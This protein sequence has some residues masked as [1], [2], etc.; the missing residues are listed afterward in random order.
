MSLQTLGKKLYYTTRDTISSRETI[1][2]GDISVTFPSYFVENFSWTI[3]TERPV[4][5]DLLTSV[6][7]GDSFYDIGA[8]AGLYSITV[9]RAIRG[10][11]TAFE[12]YPPNVDRLSRY[13]R[14]NEVDA[15]IIPHALSD[16]KTDTANLAGEK[17]QL[18]SKIGDDLVRDGNILRPDVVKI[19][20]EG[21]ELSVIRGL[22]DSLRHCRLVYCEVHPGLLEER[23]IV[24]EMIV[25]I[26]EANGFTTEVIVEREQTNVQPILRAE[27]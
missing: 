5:E 9:G 22:E 6:R 24:P 15:R 25:E 12:P 19:D 10:E 2:F 17:K 13:L 16:S 11:I 3:E 8:H 18:D 14:W 27:K 23:D 7:D 21:A 4:I 26:M 1:E 20:V